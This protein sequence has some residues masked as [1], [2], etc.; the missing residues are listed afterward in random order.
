[1]PGRSR[2]ITQLL[3]SAEGG[4]ARAADQLMLAVYN[5]LRALAR[6]YL[7]RERPNHTLQATSLVHEAY[8]QL[9]DQSRV[10]WNGR[11]HFFATAAQAMRRILVDHARKHQAAKRGR[12]RRHVPLDES[13][14]VAPRRDEDLLALDDVL[15]KLAELDPVQARLVELRVFAGLSVADAAAALSM[16]KRTAEREWTMVRAWL[17]RQLSQDNTP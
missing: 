15:T 4:D 5:E 7:A 6:R 9:V 2:D 1:M 12:G 11:T 3:E 13:L 16:S 14:I 8:L 17:R 10:Q